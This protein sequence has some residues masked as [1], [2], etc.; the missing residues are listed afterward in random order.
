[1]ACDPDDVV[2]RPARRDDASA[3]AEVNVISW[4]EGYADLISAEYL[5]GMDIAQ[6]TERW[7]G[8]LAHLRP[9]EAIL[10]AEAD[11]GIIGFTALGPS[12]DSDVERGTTEIYALYLRPDA[13]GQGVARLL[14]RTVLHGV[15]A[16]A[17]VTLWVLAANERARRFYRRNGFVADG[18]ERVGAV[19]RMF[20]P[21][22]PLPPWVRCPAGH[23]PRRVRTS[24]RSR[25]GPSRSR[26]HMAFRPP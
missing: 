6:R 12:R 21:G 18:A 15:P 26:R 9:S 23:P 7:A 10:V 25:S 11:A 22:G 4:R 17:P 13:W 1:M 24:V 3:I 2:V 8:R 19:R 14:V 16:G 20:L 5:D